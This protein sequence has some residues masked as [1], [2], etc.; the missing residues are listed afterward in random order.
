[1]WELIIYLKSF[2]KV[3]QTS[4]YIQLVNNLE[5]IRFP[6]ARN[7]SFNRELSDFLKY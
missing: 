3:K 5:M 6:T 1:M 2:D 7:K 4:Q